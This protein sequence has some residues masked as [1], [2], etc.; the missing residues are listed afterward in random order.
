[1]ANSVS[2]GHRC[3]YDRFFKSIDTRLA[4]YYPVEYEEYD[5]S[6]QPWTERIDFLAYA[7]FYK[8]VKQV[9]YAPAKLKAI[10]EYSET[11]SSPP[12]PFMINQHF[13]TVILTSTLISLFSAFIQKTQA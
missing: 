4:K 6:H 11:L 1:M 12:K 8:K 2:D 10:M 9:G 7:F 3:F 13:I 5:I